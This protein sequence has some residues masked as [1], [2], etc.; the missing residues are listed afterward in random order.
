MQSRRRRPRACLCSWTFFPAAAFR[1]RF[2]SAVA[3]R[4][5][6]RLAACASEH[7]KT[8]VSVYKR[9][10]ELEAAHADSHLR[11]TCRPNATPQTQHSKRNRVA[12][13]SAKKHKRQRRKRQSVTAKREKSQT[14]KFLTAILT[15]PNLT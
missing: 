1:L 13:T 6:K 10:R 11:Q 7:P 3:P 2:D 12:V 15:L 4:R 5:L 8:S 14:P 9:R